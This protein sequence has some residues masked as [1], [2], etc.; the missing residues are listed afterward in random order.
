MRRRDIEAEHLDEPGEAG[1]LALRELEH[2]PRQRGRVDDRVLERAFQPPPDQPCIE[3]VMAV[4]DQHGA[5]SEPQERAPR[6]A[7]LRRPDE[8]R[9]IDVM[10]A[11]RVRV[12]RRLAVDERV[13]E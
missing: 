6:I 2:E 1:G 7:K 4:L 12:D 10:P 11:V 13:E 3:R 5:S 8:H 9:P